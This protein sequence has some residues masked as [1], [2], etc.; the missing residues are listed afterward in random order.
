MLNEAVAHSRDNSYYS[1]DNSWRDKVKKVMDEIKAEKTGQQLPSTSANPQVKTASTPTTTQRR[2]KI[3]RTKSTS[4]Q[5]KPTTKKAAKPVVTSPQPTTKPATQQN[6]QQDDIPQGAMSTIRRQPTP[7]PSPV[8][9][10]SN[11]MNA[12]NNNY[13]AS[14]FL[15]TPVQQSQPVASNPVARPITPT[16]SQAP[17]SFARPTDQQAINPTGAYTPRTLGVDARRE[18]ATSSGQPTLWQKVKNFFSSTPTY[19]SGYGNDAAADSYAMNLQKQN[20]LRARTPMTQ[21]TGNPVYSGAGA[22]GQ[23]D[24]LG[25]SS[26]QPRPVAPTRTPVPT[27]TNSGVRAGAEGQEDLLGVPSTQPS[28]TSST[29]STPTTQPSTGTSSRSSDRDRLRAMG[30]DLARQRGV[31]TTTT[32]G[33][34]GRTST[35]TARGTYV[36]GVLVDENGRAVNPA[37]QGKVDAANAI[38]RQMQQASG[39]AG[40][41]GITRSSR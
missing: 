33:Q 36:G 34:G 16:T 8:V 17:I 35:T 25:N 12:V 37:E 21:P 29:S 2:S 40:G 39:A 15:R 23:L 11:F 5:R 26:V 20:A 38:R 19:Q 28:S 32:D 30:Q 27:P 24:L 10:Q 18:L 41:P 7:R 3:S 14:K 1:K 4:G 9:P 22:E 6:S 13:N 31:T